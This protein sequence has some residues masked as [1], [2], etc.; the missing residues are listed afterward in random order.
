MMLL[1]GLLVSSQLFVAVADS[2]PQFDVTPSCR[3]A[4]TGGM[5]TL[6]SC[7]AM[8][9]KAREQL[10]QE[11]GKFPAADRTTCSDQTRQYAPSYVELIECLQMFREAGQMRRQE[12]TG[13]GAPSAQSPNR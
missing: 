13:Q 6:E 12:T 4:I 3:G 5:S 10:V 11:W 2:V 8:E 7:T 1:S 9:K